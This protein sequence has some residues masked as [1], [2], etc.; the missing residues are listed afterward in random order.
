[1]HNKI[2]GQMPSLGY[3]GCRGLATA[4]KKLFVSKL[5]QKELCPFMEIIERHHT[6]CQ[7]K[8]YDIR[9][10]C[11]KYRVTDD[12]AGRASISG[13]QIMSGLLHF[14]DVHIDLVMTIL[15]QF[16]ISKIEN[17]V[18]ETTSWNAEDTKIMKHIENA[19]HSI[20]RARFERILLESRHHSQ[21]EQNGQQEHDLKIWAAMHLEFRYHCVL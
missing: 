6:R 12:F 1:V 8:C 7:K 17:L 9:D 16:V 19:P 2:G 21:D 5:I 4:K 14:A 11:R 3:R 10:L 18:R 13:I 15:M 20:L